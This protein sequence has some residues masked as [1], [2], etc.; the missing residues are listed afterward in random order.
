MDSMLTPILSW[1]FLFAMC[2]AVFLS[3]A[4][5][6]APQPELRTAN[7]LLSTL[8]LL[9]TAV[10][11]HTWLGI[12]RLHAQFPHSVL[13]I[14][15]L[16]LAAGPLLYLYVRAALCSQRPTRRALF[17]FVPFGVTTAAMLPFYLL[18]DAE[19]LASLRA[20][21]DIAWHLAVA[22]AIKLALF[23]AYL[24]ACYRLM[25]RVPPTSPL[26]RGLRQLL[27][28][29]QVGMVLSVVALAMTL[30]RTDWLLSPDELAT[31]A[32]ILFVFATAFMAMRLPLGY[33]PQPL[34]AG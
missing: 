23:M 20:V 18:P 22:T 16:G 19:K 32:L 15:T 28:I 31:I 24:V 34:P 3:M 2:Q 12:N 30:A 1:L 5:L 33:R 21:P 11:G 14:V 17:H 4:L 9:C 25:R 8:L 26:T 6:S 7:R 29:W 27:K 10:I 13:G